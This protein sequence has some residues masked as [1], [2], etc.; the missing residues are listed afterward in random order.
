MK[1][2]R[3]KTWPAD[4]RWML[5]WATGV[6]ACL[7]WSWWVLS[8]PA[9]DRLTEAAWL[10]LAMGILVMIFA[11]AWGWVTCMITHFSL[12]RGRRVITESM[13]MLTDVIRSIPQIVGVLAV[14]LVVSFAVESDV[15]VSRT[16][17]SASIALGVS[18]FVFLEVYDLMSSR[19]NHFASNELFNALRVCGMSEFRIVNVEVLWR[20]SRVM[21][22]QKVASLLGV[23]FFLLCS[24]D[25]VLSVGLS[26]EVHPVNLPP[27]LG[28]VLA[29]LDSKQ[30]ILALG[31]SISQ[32]SLIPRLLDRHWQGLATAGLLIFTLIALH[33]I[34]RGLSNRVR[35]D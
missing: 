35:H 28:S 31:M 6:G 20:S 17:I 21:I 7:G 19:L 32:P 24:V 14:Y 29:R 10:G 12:L 22:L 34:V 11:T 30:D 5:W 16:A 4:I 8:T 9:F 3:I 1:T 2:R 15:L 23:T 33:F 27:T 13:S 26:T 25:F 18:L